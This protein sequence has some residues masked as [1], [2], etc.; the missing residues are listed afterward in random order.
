M[1]TRQ[2][3]QN[4]AN[5][6]MRRAKLAR[7]EERMRLL[8]A[9]KWI[10]ANAETVWDW[11]ARLSFLE[12]AANVKPGRWTNRY[13][14]PSKIDE[15][16]GEIKRFL[17][18][19]DEEWLSKKD[20]KFYWQAFN[21]VKG[22]ISTRNIEWDPRDVMVDALYGFSFGEGEDSGKKKPEFWLAGNS[23]RVQT[24]MRK[25]DLDV[26][27][28]GRIV[29]K[30]ISGHVWSA[31]KR[32]RGKAWNV[33]PINLSEEF[34]FGEGGAKQ[35]GDY[36]SE[37]SLM[38]RPRRRSQAFYG[39]LISDHPLGKKIRNWM[40]SLWKDTTG[41]AND[42]KTQAIMDTWLRLSLAEG[43]EPKMQEVVKLVDRHNPFTVAV[44]SVYN[45][46]KK[47]KELIQEEFW[48]TDMAKELNRIVKSMGFDPFLEEFVTA[49]E[50]ALARRLV[51]VAATL[52]PE[53]K[54]RI[55][56]SIWPRYKE[57][58][59]L[60]DD[61][62]FDLFARFPKGKPA[63]P[64]KNMSPEDAAE[65]EYYN[66]YVTEKLEEGDKPGE[67]EMPKLAG[68][69]GEVDKIMRALKIVSHIG[70]KA[71]PNMTMVKGDYEPYK[72]DLK[73]GNK[74]QM[75][76][77]RAYIENHL[78]DMLGSSAVFDVRIQGPGHI[79]VDTE[80][81][82]RLASTGSFFDAVVKFAYANPKARPHLLP[83]IKKARRAN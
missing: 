79:V 55:F 41:N 81:S 9:A 77:A 40:R 49:S 69:Q 60:F 62:P 30:Y 15:A 22:T 37:R 78:D 11:M 64:T 34:E 7:G 43:E 12:G 20:T 8:L 82:G 42:Q 76:A 68:G 33:D 72:V 32:E 46:I 25:G 44:G 18:F 16:A 39:I 26:K 65:W 24:A 52:P 53:K 48:D 74:A 57:G 61:G 80:Q 13:Q 29:G 51:R 73:F 31:W 66:E 6:L 56:A 21:Q 38:D 71:K 54:H 17:P 63:D 47:Y 14:V 19:V 83:L 36:V 1:G 2:M 35:M 5:L 27:M 3:K 58:T 4:P 59:D 50:R 67:M 10:R 23:S 75:E 28:A 45:K 70:F